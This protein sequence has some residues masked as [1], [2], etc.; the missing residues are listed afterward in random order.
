MYRLLH[1]LNLIQFRNVAQYY[2]GIRQA[3]VSYTALQLVEIT[4]MT[5]ILRLSCTYDLEIMDALLSMRL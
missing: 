2:N 4:G 5:V 1:D 3:E